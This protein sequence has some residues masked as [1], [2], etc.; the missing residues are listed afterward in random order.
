MSSEIFCK[1]DPLTCVISIRIHPIRVSY[2]NSSTIITPNSDEVLWLQIA[3]TW[4]TIRVAIY[5]YCHFFPC[6]YISHNSKWFLIKYMERD[7]KKQACGCGFSALKLWSLEILYE[8][9]Y[10]IIHSYKKIPYTKMV[11]EKPQCSSSREANFLNILK[12]T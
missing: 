3:L 12:P 10:N 7:L 1:F 5:Y 6:F 8:V 4:R 11:Y 9:R 2:E